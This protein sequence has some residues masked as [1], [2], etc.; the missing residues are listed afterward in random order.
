MDFNDLSNKMITF[1]AEVSSATFEAHVH[2]FLKDRV[3]MEFS[4]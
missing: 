1:K 3:Y 2:N 4:S